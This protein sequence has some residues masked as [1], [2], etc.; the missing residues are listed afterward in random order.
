MANL[1]YVD[2]LG[3][4]SLLRV[5]T[6]ERDAELLVPNRVGS[7]WWMMAGVVKQEST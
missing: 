2:G 3:E 4:G 6:F 5:V 7:G 1:F